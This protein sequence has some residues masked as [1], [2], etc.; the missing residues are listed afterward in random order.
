MLPKYELLDAETRGDT[1]IMKISK[2]ER[3]TRLEKRAK[4]AATERRR[5]REHFCFI[6]GQQ[7]SQVTLLISEHALLTVLF[8]FASV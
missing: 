2:V 6:R 7:S 4:M 3:A 5:F 1:R 8:Y